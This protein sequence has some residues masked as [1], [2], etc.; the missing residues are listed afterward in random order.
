MERLIL[1]REY[2]DSI[3]DIDIPKGRSV[4]AWDSGI[5]KTFLFEFLKNY[6][7]YPKTNFSVLQF[8]YQ[9]QDLVKPLLDA[10]QAKRYDVITFDNA[11]LYLQ[12]E[13][14]LQANELSDFVIVACHE[15]GRAGGIP[16]NILKLERNDSTYTLRGYGK[17]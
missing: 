5:G 9:N 11:D 17:L 3:F 7:A 8:N 16:F 15:F 1:K 12:S 14:A 2:E 4:I 10:M 6:A 13:M